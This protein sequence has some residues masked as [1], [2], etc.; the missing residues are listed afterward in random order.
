M[1]SLLI[2]IK[3]IAFTILNFNEDTDPAAVHNDVWEAAAGGV[4]QDDLPAGSSQ[5][6]DY[7]TL[8]RISSLLDHGVPFAIASR[9]RANVSAY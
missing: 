4:R 3:F 8:V 1:K 7:R 9:S 2:R 6:F 5:R